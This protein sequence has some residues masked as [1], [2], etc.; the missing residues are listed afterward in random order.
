MIFSRS[1]ENPIGSQSKHILNSFLA[2]SDSTAA[3]EFDDKAIE[4]ISSVDEE[5]SHDAIQTP[6]K[7]LQKKNRVACDRGETMTLIL[8]E[9][10]DITFPEDRGLISTIQQLAETA[11]RPIIL[12]SSS[13]RLHCLK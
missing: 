10:V 7:H 5:Y 9:D 6:E 2:P 13:K 8:F 4:L 1:L 11:K 3:Q 12:T